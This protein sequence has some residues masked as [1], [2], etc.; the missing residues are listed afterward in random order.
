MKIGRIVAI[1]GAV[2]SVLGAIFYLQGQ[3]VVGPQSSFMYSNPE[4]TTHGFQI[5]VA[6][7]V[8]SALGIT[9]ALKRI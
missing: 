9:L 2:I 4:W 8:M 3:S 7:A 6:G 1:G 5:L